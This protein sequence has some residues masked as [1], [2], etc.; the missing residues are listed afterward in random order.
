MKCYSDLE[1]LESLFFD[2]LVNY[3]VGIRTLGEMNLAE[4]TLYYFRERV[5]QYCLENPGKDDL[6]FGQFIKLL[7]DFSKK[8]GISLEE[9]RI[10][11]NTV[12]E[13]NQK[14]CQRRLKID[15]FWRLNFDPLSLETDELSEGGCQIT[16]FR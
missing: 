15:P 10:D 12:H 4:R 3:A 7:H 2:Y 6:L 5:Y 1:L 16:S 14:G 9:Q 13:Q 8:A 11:T